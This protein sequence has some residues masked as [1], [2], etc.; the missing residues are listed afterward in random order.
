[1]QYWKGIDFSFY[2]RGGSSYV[3]DYVH[4]MF[5]GVVAEILGKSL[6]LLLKYF[7]I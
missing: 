7:E 2:T 6:V 5:Y 3:M 4:L 1:M